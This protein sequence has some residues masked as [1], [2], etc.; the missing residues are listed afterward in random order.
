MTEGSPK[1][2]VYTKRLQTENG[3]GT[4]MFSIHVDEGW[5]SWILCCDMY[6]WAADELIKRLDVHPIIKRL[7]LQPKEWPHP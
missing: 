7:D 3:P 4:N 5:A 1:N 2:P 6:E